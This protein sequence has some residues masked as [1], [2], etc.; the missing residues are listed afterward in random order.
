VQTN[1]TFT[2]SPQPGD[3]NPKNENHD[4]FV[5]TGAGD[6]GTLAFLENWHEIRSNGLLKWPGT[7]DYECNP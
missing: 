6:F 4:V 5:H 7:A 3:F 2:I 1:Q